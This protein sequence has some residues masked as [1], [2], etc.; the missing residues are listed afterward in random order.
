MD[1]NEYV[2]HHVAEA[3]LRQ[4]R[5]D[6]TRRSLLARLS[7]ARQETERRTELAIA[8]RTRAL[9]TGV[10]GTPAKAFAIAARIVENAGAKL[11]NARRG[12]TSEG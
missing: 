6:A 2:L 7:D 1:T 5:A 8:A 4:A 12:A 3:R 11:M 9:A 10:R